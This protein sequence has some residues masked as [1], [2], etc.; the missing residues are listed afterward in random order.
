MQVPLIIILMVRSAFFNMQLEILQLQ[1][2]VTDKV[3]INICFTPLII[4]T[5]IKPPYFLVSLTIPGG[6]TNNWL[7]DEIDAH[8]YVVK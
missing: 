5:V 4:I 1:N 3:I 7:I 8:S 2:D 6:R